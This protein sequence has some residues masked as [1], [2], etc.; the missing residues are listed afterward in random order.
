M[1]SRQLIL[2]THVVAWLVAG[3]ARLNESAREAADE[4]LRQGTLCVASI[5]FWELAML[6]KKGR[7]ELGRTV[8]S[9]RSELLGYGVVELSLDGGIGVAAAEL[10][11]LHPD[12]ADRFIVASAIA[13]GATLVTADRRLLAWPGSLNTLAAG[14]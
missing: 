13:A 3:D 5:S 12:P 4:A 6:Q 11:A 7:L 2:D 10:R 9:M 8:G 1:G 14:R